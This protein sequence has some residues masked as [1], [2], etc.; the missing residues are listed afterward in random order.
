MNR[1]KQASIL[2]SEAHWL[3][4]AQPFRFP[5]SL[6]LTLLVVG[7]CAILKPCCLLLYYTVQYWEEV[8][9]IVFYS[10]YH[11]IISFEFRAALRDILCS[12]WPSSI[13]LFF[14][15]FFFFFFC[16]LPFF[17]QSNATY[18]KK[19]TIFIHCRKAVTR[20]TISLSTWLYTMQDLQC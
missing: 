11:S 4:R 14:F 12:F 3:H 15:F 6:V 2:S 5:L 19:T 7:A 20:E 10:K 13:E 1:C 17:F 16:F 8:L 9:V 18:I